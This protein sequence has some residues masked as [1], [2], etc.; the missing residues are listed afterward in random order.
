MR[1]II[2]IGNK[3]AQLYIPCYAKEKLLVDLFFSNNLSLVY[4]SY[5]TS[6]P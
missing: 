3:Y 5:K 1:K 4:W 2:M 6:M